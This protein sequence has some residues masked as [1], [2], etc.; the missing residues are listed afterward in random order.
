MTPQLDSTIQ[1]VPALRERGRRPR[2][3]RTLAI[4]TVALSALSLGFAGTAN[5]DQF[6]QFS[7]SAGAPLTRWNIPFRDCSIT[8][9]PVADP[10]VPIGS[11]NYRTI[12]GAQVNCSTKHT[13]AVTVREWASNGPSTWQVGT[14]IG[15]TFPHTYGFGKSIFELNL[16][17]Q[18]HAYYWTTGVYVNLDGNYN[19][20]WLY[21][22][23]SDWKTTGC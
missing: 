11:P 1:P 5:A 21:S 17:C 18:G 8:V 2:L 6:N 7:N 10:S 3:G 13:I 23:W 22:P 20:G 14:G 12:G 19:S 16:N 9:G 15:Q 4:A